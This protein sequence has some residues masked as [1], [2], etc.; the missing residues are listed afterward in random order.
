MPPNAT[1]TWLKINIVATNRSIM[2]GQKRIIFGT[3]C[4]RK[5][6]QKGDQSFLRGL[7]Y[8]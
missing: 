8:K 6:W 3:K 2:L 1:E 7:V 5:F 4:E